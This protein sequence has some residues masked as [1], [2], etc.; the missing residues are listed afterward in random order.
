LR[1]WAEM[2][3]AARIHHHL[4]PPLR[5]NEAGLDIEGLSVASGSMGGD[6]A[7][8]VMLPDGAMELVVADVSG[9]GVRAGVVMAMLKSLLHARRIGDALMPL[10]QAMSELNRVLCDLAEPGMF[11]TMAIARIGRD[12]SVRYASAGHPPLLLR[13][14]T[15]VERLCEGSL[16]LGVASDARFDEHSATL[17]HGAALVLY[18]D[19]LVEVHVSKSRLLGLDGL[20]DVVREARGS[21]AGE[22]L[23]A[24][25]AGVQARSTDRE[26]LDDQTAVVALRR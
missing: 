5:S 25:F 8:C 22:L 9:H 16:P 26:Q 2:D 10:P 4:V 17:D 15:A 13:H 18:S 19:G 7:E 21:D 14:G 6:L 11:A 24:F 20:V 12:G 1:L 23:R 3:L